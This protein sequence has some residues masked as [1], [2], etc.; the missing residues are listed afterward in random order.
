MFSS[1]VFSDKCWAFSNWS[2]ENQS[3]LVGDTSYF[4]VPSLQLH[5]D[6]TTTHVAGS[7]VLDRSGHLRNGMLMNGAQ[8]NGDSIHG[9]VDLGSSGYLDLGMGAGNL[10]GNLNDF[11][12]CCWVNPNSLPMWG[13]IFDFGFDTERFMFL[14]S[15]NN[16][17]VPRFSLKNNADEQGVNGVALTPG[18]WTHFAVVVDYDSLL[19]IGQAKI[20]MDGE[21][22]GTNNNI[23]I[24]P[25]DLGVTLRNY[26]GKSMWAT[27]PGLDA[28]IADFRVYSGALSNTDVSMLI[29]AL[30]TSSFYLN[31]DLT[32][33]QFKAF[34]DTAANLN[35]QS[36][37]S[38]SIL[39]NQNWLNVQPSSGTGNSTIVVSADVNPT[40]FSRSAT[41]TLQA[42]NANSQVVTV[43]QL[44]DTTSSL[45]SYSV[46]ASQYGELP[47]LIDD[48]I[49][50][51]ITKLTVSGYLNSNDLNFI[52]YSF[53]KLTDVDL[54]ASTIQW[55]TI[56]SNTFDSWTSLDR[57]VLPESLKYI[58]YAAF[59][60]CISLQSIN[61]PEMLVTLGSYAFQ[62][63]YSLNEP[64]EFP[65][66]LTH[67]GYRAFNGCKFLTCKSNAVVAPT[68]E[69]GSLGG[70]T[71][72]YIP[73]GSYISYVNTWPGIALIT[74]DTLMTVTVELTSAGTMGEAVLQQVDYLRQVNKLIVSGPMNYGDFELI[75]Y[76]MPNLISLDLKHAL[77]SYIPS[78]Q[79]E[80]KTAMTEII[81][82]DVLESIEYY[83]FEQCI[84]LT[85][86][87]LPSM[88]TS[89]GEYAFNGCRSLKTIVLPNGLSW[90]GEG[91]F[92]NCSSLDSVMIPESITQIS[93]STF[94]YCKN[95]RTVVLP[96]QLTKIGNSAFYECPMTSIQ[97]PESILTIEANAFA[98]CGLT[99][100]QIPSGLTKLNYGVFQG[101]S[102]D[103]IVIPPAIRWMEYGALNC[104][105][106]KSIRCTQPTPTYLDENPFE[107][108]N[109]NNCELYV[110]HYSLIP[111]KLA[112][113]WRDF[114]SINSYF[115]T[116][117][118]MPISGKLMLANNVR[119]YGLP[120]V[121]IFSS[122][123]LFVGGSAPFQTNHFEME[124]TYYN[125]WTE[126]AWIYKSNAALVNECP[127]MS[128]NS[129]KLTFEMEG[130]RWYYLTFPF[131][132]KV[133]DL[134]FS[135]NALYSVRKYDGAAR[136][137]SGAGG[138]WKNMTRDSVLLAKT[139]YVFQC[140]TQ[141]I[142]SVTPMDSTS[143]RIFETAN[144]L[145]PLNA[146]PSEYAANNGWNF[147]GNPYPSYFDSR[148]I[149]Y[150]APIT[151]WNMDNWT[152]NAISLTDDQYALKPFESFFVQKPT[153]VP[154]I[155][156]LAKGR[157]LSSELPERPALRSVKANRTLLNLTLK[158]DNFTD[159]CRVVLNQQAKLSYEM[160][161]DA[162][163]FMSTRAEASQLYSL[164]MD[165]FRYAINERPIESGTVKL[166]YVAGVAGSHVF[167]VSDL[168]WSNQMK[169]LLVDQ[170]MKTETDLSLQSYEFSSDKG[171]FDDR[172]ML[173]ITSVATG[174]ATVQEDPTQVIVEGGAVVVHASLGRQ[175]TIHTLNGVQLHRFVTS[176]EETRIPLAKGIYL[177]RV[178]DNVFKSVVF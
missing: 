63:C 61:M 88:L 30:D 14:T 41:L 7:F 109:K 68:I 148:L 29:S 38:W 57:M 126:N 81:L 58:E 163:K 47:S 112:A 76:S 128:A 90:I 82:P 101:C 169:V 21:L 32:A 154:N 23:T 77:V 158:N 174:N 56:Y 104:S 94:G 149:D 59:N 106:L 10:I 49:R 96:S 84:S 144:V 13:R 86:L 71:T 85:S 140:N 83:A 87:Q 167:A 53:P 103:S 99:S 67:I 15:N 120:D 155:G 129:V 26:I 100:V 34:N 145:V 132:V 31:L 28:R 25:S 133:M 171:T 39:S 45:S 92:Y 54:S 51:E 160:T 110:P 24:K 9:S 141:A 35:I 151:V 173:K 164:D 98:Y 117:E 124:N 165:G 75:R 107:W 115:I 152:Y 17:G 52:R 1:L 55:N 176:N 8:L 65:A 27:D 156:F 153:D 33:I 111:Y 64:L 62:G 127:N 42:A 48:Y 18:R 166:G 2:T 22:V 157:L 108:V 134:A 16:E 46:Y 113:Y 125:Y 80:G 130:G 60:N 43:I 146:Y 175:I 97:L 37:T 161:C 142:M 50:D 105:T 89:I 5:Y 19:S 138:S 20:Y 136:A 69:W 131:N 122:G 79:F 74:G 162:S 36:N 123:K 159:K 66:T 143:Q 116:P 147:V 70:I 12:I 6:F 139:G 178:D 121:T 114:L 170:L 177:V 93:S 73:L 118:T 44:G 119:P 102:L 91:A 135:N 78:S 40:R 4:E 95:L 11:S 172:F 168:A 137:L 150:T 72:A 3:N